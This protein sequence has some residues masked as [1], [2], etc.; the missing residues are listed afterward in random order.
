M[1][2]QTALVPSSPAP[3][4]AASHVIVRRIAAVGLLGVAGLCGYIAAAMA[5]LNTEW[6]PGWVGLA[7]VCA[8]GA[9]AQ[10]VGRPWARG[11]GLG[12][13]IWGLIVS[14]QGC[15]ALGPHPF[16][17]TGVAGMT[18]LT[19]LQLLGRGESEPGG[20]HL[21]SMVLA[22]AAVP[23]ATIYGLAPQHTLL[24]SGG[25]LG[26]ALVVLAGAWG[27]CRGRT[28][29]LLLGLAGSVVMGLTLAQAQAV[30]WLQHPHPVLPQ[31]NPL[32]LLALGIAGVG[33]SFS[34]SAI[35]L[36]PMVRFVLRGDDA[37]SS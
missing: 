18:V 26:G 33:L 17:L 3:E 19:G 29:G 10:W 35:F 8:V 11:Y 37:A 4:R 13:T 30:G 36:A 20:R 31:T 23:C 16:L 2:S 7:L 22:S 21:L 6:I 5:P 1:D 24:V 25:V 27:V 12:I 14:V 15:F 9:H 34:S 32:A 28:W